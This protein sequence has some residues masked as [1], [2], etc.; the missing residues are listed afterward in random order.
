V[1][2]HGT[3]CM[4]WECRCGWF[5]KVP[6]VWNGIVD[7]L[8]RCPEYAMSLVGTRCSEWECRWLGNVPHVRNGMMDGLEKCPEYGLFVAFEQPGKL[9]FMQGM[10]QHDTRCME[11]DS[12]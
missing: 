5:E 4:K 10:V 8:E 7:G 1:V 11:R 6:R 12:G 3:W 2:R 9:G